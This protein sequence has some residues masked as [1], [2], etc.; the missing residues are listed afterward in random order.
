MQI[1]QY[2]LVGG[3]L[4]AYHLGPACSATRPSFQRSLGRFAQPGGLP[5]E[6]RF[7]HWVGPWFYQTWPVRRAS[8]KRAI[9]SR[10]DTSTYT[11]P[12]QPDHSNRLWH[13]TKLAHHGHDMAR[14]ATSSSR[15]DTIPA[16]RADTCTTRP[17]RPTWRWSGTRPSDGLAHTITFP[18]S[19]SLPNPSSPFS[20]LPYRC[21]PVLFHSHLSPP[22]LTAHHL[23]KARESP[24][25]LPPLLTLT[26]I[27]G[28]SSQGTSSLPT[29][30]PSL[31]TLRCSNYTS[32]CYTPLLLS[33]QF[34]SSQFHKCFPCL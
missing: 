27:L 8:N 19:A 34:C 33:T 24:S 10:Q 30:V 2:P 7:V 21:I 18:R 14:P 31:A 22:S 11:C 29:C 23:V 5:A 16:R 32:K 4:S 3:K 15:P 28:C 17:Q 25:S 12:S 6:A 13:R 1:A 9:Y 20:P 26:L